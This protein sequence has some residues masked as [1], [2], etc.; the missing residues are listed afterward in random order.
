MNDQDLLLTCDH[1][2]KQ[3]F[4]DVTNEYVIKHTFEKI[5]YNSTFDELLD[6]DEC[7]VGI[8]S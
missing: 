6:K 2:E 8:H 3:I 7:S 1:Y 5:D 4:L